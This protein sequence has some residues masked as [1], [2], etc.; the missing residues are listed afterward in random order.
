MELKV[1]KAPGQDPFNAVKMAVIM[2]LIGNGV[3]YELLHKQI[4]RKA[5]H[6]V[7]MYE[8]P[9]Y[10]THNGRPV[11]FISSWNIKSSGV[12]AYSYS[13]GA[14]T[15]GLNQLF[16]GQSPYEV[17]EGD[18]GDGIYHDDCYITAKMLQ[19]DSGEINAWA[20]GPKYGWDDEDAGLYQH[21]YRDK[22]RLGNTLITNVEYVRYTVVVNNITSYKHKVILT[23]PTGSRTIELGT[24]P[25]TYIPRGEWE[26]KG[27]EAA[28]VYSGV[29][30]SW[31]KDEATTTAELV[32][33]HGPVVCNHIT[34]YNNNPWSAI[35]NNPAMSIDGTMVVFRNGVA[36]EYVAWNRDNYGD[37]YTELPAHYKLLVMVYTDTGDLVMSRAE[38]V[39]KWD[40]YFELVVHEDGEWWESLL[41]PVIAIVAVVLSVLTAGAAAPALMAA[42]G[43]AAGTVLAGMIVLGGVISALGVLSGN[44]SLMLIGGIMGGIGG[45]ASIAANTTYQ[46]TMAVGVSARTALQVT[47]ETSL[48]GLFSNM[49]SG[50]GL[51]N[52]LDIGSNVLRIFSG[53]QGL[54]ADGEQQTMPEVMDEAG[55]TVLAADEEEEGLDAVMALCNI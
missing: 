19:L 2:S 23:T 39:E 7:R 34:I 29:T 55:K 28:R 25:A 53:V 20:I 46:A 13:G 52:I 36:M 48:G 21:I 14:S 22:D 43:T 27:L 37:Y 54:G 38:F 32:A 33:Q 1:V 17:Y 42:Y 18:P 12:E 30:E 16:V 51:G 50:A 4:W 47:A 6:R 31:Q 5:P 45:L 49:V 24:D 11:K 15:F 8:N 41:A 10:R 9:L 40:E 3:V 35:F 26:L 44:K